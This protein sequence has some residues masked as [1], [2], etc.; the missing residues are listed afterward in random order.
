AQELRWE[1][2]HHLGPFE[3]GRRLPGLRLELAEA[4]LER[5]EGRRAAEG[6]GLILTPVERLYAGG[7]TAHFDSAF[8]HAQP[9]PF[10]ALHPSDAAALGV[11]R[12]DVLLVESDGVRLRL[13]AEL[14]ERV[15]AGTLQAPKGL[16]G[17]PVT[18]MC[19]GG[20]LPRVS[21][22]RQVL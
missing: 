20:A 2:Q 18:A 17:V 16:P 4:A 19:R 9:K 7:G 6:D 3:D 1:L 5:G 10:A 12:G 13:T 15:A 8:A 11:S 22:T 21:V 14:N